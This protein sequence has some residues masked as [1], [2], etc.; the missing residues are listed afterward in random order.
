LAESR[1]ATI[2][3]HNGP[4]KPVAIPSFLGVCELKSGMAVVPVLILTAVSAVNLQWGVSLV[5]DLRTLHLS[6]TA[7]RQREK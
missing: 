7:A 1:F 5:L 4:E 3:E 6:K 2:L